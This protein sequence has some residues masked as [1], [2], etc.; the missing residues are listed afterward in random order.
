MNDLENIFMR[1]R[2][3]EKVDDFEIAQLFFVPNKKERAKISFQLAEYFANTSSVDYQHKAISFIERAWLLSNFDEEM[4]PLLEDIYSRHNRISDIK[5]AYKQIGIKKAINGEVTSALEYFNKWQLTFPVF[6]NMD[7][8]E[9]DNE[10]MNAIG[11]IAEPYKCK[12]GTSQGIVK[13]RKI[14]VAHLVKGILEANSVIIKL[15][16]LFAEE[17]DSDKFELAFFMHENEKEIQSKAHSREAVK[18]FE[19]IN[20]QVFTGKGDTVLENLLSIRDSILEFNADILVTHDA[21]AN[22]NNFFISEL[23]PARKSICIM[24]GPPYLSAWYTFD[25]GI[26]WFNHTIPDSPVNTS[27]V[28]IEVELSSKVDLQSIDKSLLG[29]PP[30]NTLIVSGGRHAKYQNIN[31]WQAIIELLNANE[32]IY[33]MAL[34]FEKTDVKFLDELIPRELTNRILFIKWSKD[35]LNY[36]VTADI[37][38]DSFPVGG[39]VI[40]FEAMAMQLPVVSFKHDFIS[41]YD[42]S[43]ASGDFQNI[44]FPELLVERND[45]ENMKYKLNQLVENVNYRKEIGDK[46]QKFILEERGKPARMVKRCEDIYCTILNDNQDSEDKYYGS[47]IEYKNIAS[48]KTDI[49]MRKQKI[50]PFFTV[51]IPVYNHG[52]YL[53][54]AVDTVLEQTFTD[55]EIV[56]V[57]DGSTDNT[58]DVIEEYIKK[59]SRIRGFHKENGGVSSALNEGIKHANGKWIC[60]LSSDDFFEPD[61]LQIHF[62]EI[63][64]HPE[65]KFHISK[66]SYFYEESQTKQVAEL[67]EPIPSDEFRVL[68]L[69]NANYI[70]GNSIAI[71]RS[72]LENVGSFDEKLLQGQDFDLWLRILLKYPLHYIPKRTCTTRLHNERTTNTFTEGGVFDS[73]YALFKNCNDLS[74]SRLF[75]ENHL[76]NFENAKKAAFEAIAITFKHDSFLHRLGYS[77]FLID[78]I[79]NW[80]VNEC[81]PK[82]KNSLIKKVSSISKELM[83]KTNSQELK[84]I[85]GALQNIKTKDKYDFIEVVQQ[86][87]NKVMKNGQQ[88]K[89]IELERF[90]ERS[91]RL[92]HVGWDGKE[93]FESTYFKEWEK[94]QPECIES[95]AI[96][97]LTIMP[98]PTR[99]NHLQSEAEISC[100][101]C[102]NQFKVKDIYE[103]KVTGH[104]TKCICP[105]CKTLYQFSD[106]QFNEVVLKINSR[107]KPANGKP[108]YDIAY[109]VKEAKYIGGGS[110]IVFKHID[111]LIQLGLNVTV[112]SYSEK[113]DW[114]DTDLDFYTISCI[115]DITKHSFDK[116]VAFS[117]FDVPELL[118]LVKK[119]NVF[120][121]CQ[122]YEGYH[123]G[124]DYETMRED[125]FL[126]TA[127]H[128]LPFKT[129]VVSSHLSDLFK[130]K[131]NKNSYYIPNGIDLTTFYNTGNEFEKRSNSITFIGNPF[132]ILKGFPFLANTLAGI[133]NSKF[134]IN[135]LELNIIYGAEIDNFTE[136]VKK[137]E[138]HSGAKVNLLCK[139]NS[140]QVAK[141]IS[142][143]KLVTCT[144]MYEGFSIPLLEAMATGT[145]VITTSNMGAESFCKDNVNSFVVN[146]NDLK[147]FAEKILMV[148]YRAEQIKSLIENGYS[149]VKEYSEYNSANAFV[150]QF[151]K[152]LSVQFE[153]LKKNEFLKQ[154]IAEFESADSRKPQ[155]EISMIIPTYNKVEYVKK[156][157]E[158]LEKNVNKDYEIII[159]DD[160]STENVFEPFKDNTNVT[161][162][163]NEIN[164][165]FSK[166]VNLGIK[167]ATGKYILLVNNDTICTKGSIERMI[168]ITETDDKIG[169]VGVVSNNAS[170]PQWDKKANYET[171]DQMHTYAKKI[172][173]ENKGNH[174]VFPRIA[175]LFTLIKR[176]V[177]DKIGGLDER[178]SP[179]YYEDDDFCLR[180]QLAGFKGVIAEDV[181]IHHYGS[182]TFIE[183]GANAQNSLSETNRNKFTDK[184]DGNPDEIWLK[185]KQLRIRNILYPINNSIFIEA[186]S[187]TLLHSEESEFNL[188][189]AEVE[190]AI[191]NF[192]TSDRTGYEKL[193]KGDVLNF[194]G[195]IALQYGELEKAQ[196]YL[197]KELEL[198]P[199]SAT[200]CF[201][202]AET[203]YSAE[204]YEDSKTMYEWAIKNGMDNEGIWD[205]MKVVNTMLGLEPNHNSLELFDEELHSTIEQVEEL[206]NSSDL[207]EAEYKL[208][209]LLLTAPNSIEAL[210]DLAV[211]K[212][213]QKS[214]ADALTHLSTV[215]SIDPSN[216]IALENLNYIESEINPISSNYWSR[217]RSLFYN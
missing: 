151:S 154:F 65:K 168:E 178:F 199:N 22:F 169:L 107:I 37:Y 185:G 152:L 115:N 145:P 174:F 84:Q 2:N 71:E 166:S 141:V 176:E 103:M 24:Y 94:D 118:K 11:K 67:W 130:E 132:H 133:S 68:H 31:Y 49:E 63:Q 17:F 192:E 129:I 181:F 144:S 59:D 79:C 98:Q 8:Y 210:N 9:Y 73:T 148:F 105:S 122:G 183:K 172:R 208:N 159:V 140:A 119:D 25:L 126:L 216:E 38:L 61:K 109:F 194:A 158:S 75:P 121:F 100:P 36:L 142:S 19:D 90:L 171:L 46:C 134:K 26:S 12:T 202:L 113:P 47:K 205:K 99:F 127:M 191:E 95:A 163:R 30:N 20:C 3:G 27:L 85:L 110:K 117:I 7:K 139:L 35:Y 177:I 147:S 43:N 131:F 51:V 217:K 213:M 32:K 195:N 44:P 153:D 69:F 81:P 112:F 184:W 128:E 111:W 162:L 189:L 60:W 28:P 72:V 146:Y 196:D 157:V 16:K 188:A 33:F 23:K 50:A 40:L 1:F 104:A 207:D 45:F 123:Y 138:E 108:K 204:L 4:L 161:A 120:L 102:S 214:Y 54:A 160:A 77:S 215:I 165:G 52:K 80:I 106:E 203:F 124:T 96:D 86:T 180:A 87:I 89:A 29:I 200:A 92:G 88:F 116:I 5:K 114:V 83:L 155:P 156:A 125:K 212:I 48:T 56:L 93:K 70:H 74:F 6:A 18:Y 197:Q 82:I 41:K 150:N 198:N 55:W 76:N 149:T 53:P 39:V 58:K 206:I 13:N 78:K 190:R 10:I 34:G 143:S 173:T 137:I 66:W 209:E 186:F 201:G 187:R 101:T 91:S 136:W 170:G 182:M 97:N 167:A 64:N 164:S 135:D 175:F 193:S 179:G 14:R 42:S 211:V 62:D 21:L 57:N 15:N